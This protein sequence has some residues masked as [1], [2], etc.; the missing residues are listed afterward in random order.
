MKWS[1]SRSTTI[2]LLLSPVGILLISITRLLIVSDYNST[3]AS[4]IASSGGYV[5]TLLGTFVPVVPLFMPYFALVLLFL[6]RTVLA[7]L[8][9]IAAVLT[10]P[11][12]I[13][14]TELIR[15]IQK[16][17]RLYSNNAHLQIAGALA[18]FSSY[19]LRSRF[20]VSIFD[21]QPGPHR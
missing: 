20:S 14:K 15:S 16:D 13:T 8:A 18:V 21:K 3:T 5:N 19:F 11:T 1:L 10:S 17:G 9:S 12:A 2:A 6:D 7:I 4:T